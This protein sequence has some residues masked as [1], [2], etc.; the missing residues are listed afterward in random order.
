MFSLRST[1]SRSWNLFPCLDRSQATNQPNSLVVN[2]TI[3]REVT[4]LKC[5]PGTAQ[6][7]VNINNTKG[8]RSVDY[9]VI[10]KQLLPKSLNE[11]VELDEPYL[12]TATDFSPLRSYEKYINLLALIQ[13]PLK[14][15][16]HQGS[17]IKELQLRVFLEILRFPNSTTAEVY[18]ANPPSTVDYG[19]LNTYKSPN[20]LTTS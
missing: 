2:I 5:L 18:E 15:L 9:S 17:V 8:Q 10:D 7:T 20:Y 3:L 11:P 12:S 6:Y 13:S 1:T 4:T 16:F 14:P 19:T